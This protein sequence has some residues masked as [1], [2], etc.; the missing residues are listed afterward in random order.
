VSGPISSNTPGSTGAAVLAVHGLVHSYPSS[1]FRLALE[2]LELV[3]GEKVALIGRSGCGKTTLLNLIAG[4]QAPDAGAV[5]WG[6][7]R[8]DTLP[9]PRR[10][11]RRLERLG[12]IFQDFCLIDHLDLLDNILL[13]FRLSPRLQLTAPV[14]ERAVALAS[15]V[16]LGDRLHASVRTLSQG[17]KQRLLICRALITEPPLVLA[18]EATSNLD[19]F[20]RDRIQ[21][22]LA[23]YVEEQRAALLA[24]THD[25]QTLNTYDRVVDLESS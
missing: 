22:T 25:R 10:R 7:E 2:R 9:E 3:A 20:T 24:V 6:G 15:E 17:E 23:A 14:R 19:P 18:D 11:D 13:P 21:S 1:G 5:H 8:I 12:F 4:I 16:G